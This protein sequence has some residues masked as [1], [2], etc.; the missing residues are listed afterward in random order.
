MNRRTKK[1]GEPQMVELEG[2]NAELKQALGDFKASVHAWSDAEF[3][4]PRAVHASATHHGLKLALGWSL[5]G[6]LLAAG[7]TGAVYMAYDRQ[8]DHEVANEQKAAQRHGTPAQQMP[9]RQAAQVPDEVQQREPTTRRVSVQAPD[10]DLLA[11]VD[12]AVSRTVPRA[13]EP[14]VYM[15]NDTGTDR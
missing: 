8:P 9:V 6:V 4:K 3:A 10:E 12:T 13:M 14:L 7:T 5:A 11:S 2:M 15:S 1:A